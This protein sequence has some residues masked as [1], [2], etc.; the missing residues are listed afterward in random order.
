MLGEAIA[1][2]ALSGSLVPENLD[3]S[4]PP[5]GR[6]SPA[7]EPELELEAPLDDP[8]LYTALDDEGEDDGLHQPELDD[9][10]LGDEG[11][12]GNDEEVDIGADAYFWKIDHSKS[13]YRLRGM[14]PNPFRVVCSC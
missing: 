1:E 9:L 3:A 11:S 5:A 10:S 6:P 8:V 12:F 7:A 13:H 4:T 14:F 2:S